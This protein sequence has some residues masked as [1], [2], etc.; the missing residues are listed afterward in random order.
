[1]TL[2]TRLTTLTLCWALTACNS[3]A[4]R[5]DG[6]GDLGVVIERA[7]GTVAVISS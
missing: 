3:L 6:T 1:M 7:N 4:S 5:T 2:W